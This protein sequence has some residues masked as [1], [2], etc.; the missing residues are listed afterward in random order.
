MLD[1]GPRFN[2]FT[3]YPENNSIDQILAFNALWPMTKLI[4]GARQGYRL[5][6]T[7]IIEAGQR[8]EQETIPTDLLAGYRFTEKTSA[9]VNLHRTSVDYE[10]GTG[11]LGYTDWNDE[12]WFNYQ[13]TPRLN[14][15]AGVTLGWLQVPDQQGQTYEQFLARA[16]YLPGERITVDASVGGQFRQFESGIDPTFEPV[17]T[18]TAYYRPLD[19]TWVYLTGY[20]REYPSV[21]EG[22]NYVMTGASLGGRQQLGDRYFLTLAVDY[23]TMD[24]TPTVPNSPSSD[25]GRKDDYLQARLGFEVRFTRHLVGTLA[26]TLRTVDS[27]TWDGFTD[28]QIGTHVTWTF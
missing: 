28:N 23:Y 22:L 20:R 12:N 7:T 14:L 5:E 6:N 15:G 10:Q 1:Y 19:A 13:A 24:Y 8:T 11:L 25:V 27:N 9:E 16:R 21:S 4:L 17:F 3:K 2:W 18:L 26:Y